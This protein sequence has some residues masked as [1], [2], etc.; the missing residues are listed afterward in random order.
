MVLSERKDLGEKKV[1]KK[2][3]KEKEKIFH[4]QLLRLNEK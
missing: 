1:E 2:E 3:R 4:Q